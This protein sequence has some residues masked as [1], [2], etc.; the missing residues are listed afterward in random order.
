MLALQ[1]KHQQE[2]QLE[3]LMLSNVRGYEEGSLRRKVAEREDH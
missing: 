2:Y 1:C 3:K